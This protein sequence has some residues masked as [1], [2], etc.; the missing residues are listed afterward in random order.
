MLRGQRHAPAALPTEKRSTG[1]SVGLEAGL[2]GSQWGFETR[3]VQLVAIRYTDSA[4]P[5]AQI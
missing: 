2:D 1:V 3:T 4:F 5:A